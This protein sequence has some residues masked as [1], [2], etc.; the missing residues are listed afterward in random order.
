ME[1]LETLLFVVLETVMITRLGWTP[2]KLLCG[3]YIK[4]ASTSKNIALIQ[5]AIRSTLKVLL[6]VPIYISEWFLILPILVLIF[7][8]F[9]Q[10]KQTF[11]DKIAK[12]VV[13]DYKPQKCHLYLNY[14]GITRRAIAYIIDRFIITGICLVFFSLAKMTFYPIKAEI[15]TIYLSFLLSIIF[16][17]FIIRRFSGTPGQLLCCTCIKDANTLENVT[18]VQATIRYVSF[19]VFNLYVWSYIFAL[20]KFSD[21]YTSEWWFEP[22]AALILMVIT[23][24]FVLVILDR[25]KQFLHDKI[26]RTVAIDYK[27]S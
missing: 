1:V 24:V 2:G 25:R 19:E 9:N 20:E 14:V 26:A 11:Y 13:I 18:I 22:L 5:A 15:L 16:G 10:R 8:V 17:V 23:L 12:T 6:C 7:V 3:I 21:K 27:P 4:D